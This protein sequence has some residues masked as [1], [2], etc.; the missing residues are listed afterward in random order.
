LCE[1]VAEQDNA[2]IAKL[3]YQLV[4]HP[5]LAGNDRA[6]AILVIAAERL[7]GGSW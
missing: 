7:R 4:F 1:Q 6:A 5:G 3:V 2:D